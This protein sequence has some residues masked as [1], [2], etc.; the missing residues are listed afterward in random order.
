M[1]YLGGQSGPD[2]EIWE[3]ETIGLTHSFFYDGRCR[4]RGIV[5]TPNTGTG[6]D[7]QGWEFYR[8]TR[9]AYGRVISGDTIYNTPKPI[10]VL[11]Q[12]DRI[13][14]HYQLGE[15]SIVERKFVS[16]N[17]VVTTIITSS[18]PIEIEFGGQTFIC[19]KSVKVGGSVTY[20]QRSKCSPYLRR[21]DNDV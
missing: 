8:A 1:M 11:W 12:P 17:D 7:F 18:Q 2:W 3:E 13:T 6:H 4:G 9:I 14:Y 21:Q 5:T 19:N 20:S 16:L 15:I 10:I